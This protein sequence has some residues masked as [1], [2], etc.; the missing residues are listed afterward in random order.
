[1]S[2]SIIVCSFSDFLSLSSSVFDSSLPLFHD[3]RDN[4]QIAGWLHHA[5]ETFTDKIS[6]L[7]QNVQ[8]KDTLVS[9]CT[10]SQVLLSLL[11][12]LGFNIF[13]YLCLI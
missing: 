11:L 13:F 10:Q 3:L 4:E 5:S 9:H 7:I 8:G 2:G 1:M 12:L 6:D